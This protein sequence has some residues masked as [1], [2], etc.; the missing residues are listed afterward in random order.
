VDV[1][2]TSIGAAAWIASEVFERDLAP[3]RCR[4][5]NANAVDA[6]VRGGLIW[7]DTTAADTISDVTGLVLMPFAAVGLD[8]LA[9][10]HEGAENNIPEDALIVAE[11]TFL[12]EDVTQLTKLLVGRERPFVHALAPEQKSQTDDPDNNNVS[13][14]SGH[15]SE[16]FALATSAGTVSE[17]RGYRY[18]PMIWSVGGTLALVTTYLRMAADRHWFTDVVVGALVGAGFGF[19]MPYVFH[20]AIDEAPRASRALA[21]RAQAPPATTLMTIPW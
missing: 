19:A 16:A 15:T 17:M 14:F 4:W 3:S 5:C 20:S 2:I 9:T 10:A 11:A 1:S 21:P 12:A 18:A 7:R 13:F 8:A 6:G